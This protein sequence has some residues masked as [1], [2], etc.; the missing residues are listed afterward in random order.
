MGNSV[1][2]PIL[3]LDSAGVVDK[4]KPYQ[5]QAIVY[6]PAAN[7]NDVIL[8][9]GNGETIIDWDASADITI[10]PQIALTFPVSLRVRGLDVNTIDGGNLFIYLA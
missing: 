4:A 6:K 10:T 8:F 1:V 2:G 9:D 5:I 7:S 3:N